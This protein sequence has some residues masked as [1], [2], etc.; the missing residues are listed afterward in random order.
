MFSTQPYGFISVYIV[1]LPWWGP[2]MFG[3]VQQCAHVGPLP[4]GDIDHQHTFRD[5][6][7][8]HLKKDSRWSLDVRFYFLVL[9]GSNIKCTEWTRKTNR[10][11]G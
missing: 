1:L 6:H 5:R 7:R 8:G 2:V 9:I 10:E 4:P 3:A 11:G